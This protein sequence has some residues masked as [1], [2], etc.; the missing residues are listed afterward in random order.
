MEV[1]WIT[2]AAARRWAVASQFQIN[3]TLVPAPRSTQVDNEHLP[4]IEDIKTLIDAAKAVEEAAQIAMKVDAG[5]KR[6]VEKLAVAALKVEE[7][8]SG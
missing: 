2:G 8:V 1:G 3:V 7:Q 4:H 5:L 6:A